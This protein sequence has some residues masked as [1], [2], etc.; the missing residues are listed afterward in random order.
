MC[1]LLLYFLG[2]IP[3]KN[4]CKNYAVL[5]QEKKRERMNDSKPVLQ[6][7]GKVTLPK[8]NVKKRNDYK[9]SKRKSSSIIEN[10]GMINNKPN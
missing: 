3:P 7:L 1:F 4:K 6:H 10:Y 8:A 5:Q 9:R 2:A